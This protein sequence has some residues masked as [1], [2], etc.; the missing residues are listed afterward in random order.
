MS[1]TTPLRAKV[2]SAD[3]PVQS[4]HQATKP[5]SLHLAKPVIGRYRARCFGP[6]F[7]RPPIEFFLILEILSNLLVE[8]ISQ[9]FCW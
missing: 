6:C 9:S 1:G 2:E 4:Q 8:S 7:K 5:A 3:L